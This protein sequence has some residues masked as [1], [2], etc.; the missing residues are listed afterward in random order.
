MPKY[1]VNLSPNPSFEINTSN[2]VLGGS[3]ATA[4]RSVQPS[5]SGSACLKVTLSS[6]PNTFTGVG[7]MIPD[8]DPTV[9]W[10]AY[11]VSVSSIGAARKFKTRVI[12]YNSGG[13]QIGTAP[14]SEAIDCAA[15]TWVRTPTHAIQTPAGAAT[16]R[17]YL[18]VFAPDGTSA[19]DAGAVWLTD[20][21]VVSQGFTESDARKDAT[22]FFDG[23][24][25]G[26][27]WTGAV[28]LS[29]SRRAGPSRVNRF[30]NPSSEAGTNG[31]VVSSGTL[32]RTTSFKGQMWNS[33][34]GRS[35]VYIT[36]LVANGTS[37][38]LTATA[39][40]SYQVPVVPGQ[41]VG[42]SV[43]I[44]SDPLGTNAGKGSR[45]EVQLI[46]SGGGAVG[47]E[48]GTSYQPAPL[49]DG[50]RY[51]FTFQVPAGVYAVRPRIQNFSGNA[52]TSLA[53]GQRAWF[54]SLVLTVGDTADEASAGVTTG[55]FDGDGQANVYMPGYEINTA[56]SGTPHD[57]ASY[58]WGVDIDEEALDDKL[59]WI[60]NFAPP[61]ITT[62]E[63]TRLSLG[64]VYLGHIEGVVGGSLEFAVP[65]SVKGAGTLNVIDYNQNIDWLTTRIKISCTVN[66]YEWDLGVFVPSVPKEAWS[67]TGRAWSIELL[68]KTCILDQDA[69]TGSF[70]L[71]EGT[72]VIN[73]VRSL[74]QST[75]ETA[76]SAITNTSQTLKNG[77]VWEPGTSKL[78]IIN[79]LLDTAG[80][81]A[82]WCDGSGMF[83][84]EPYTLP[85][86]RP[87][88]WE[89]SDI[90]GPKIYL[91]EFE[92]EQDIYAIPNRV[93][94]VSQTNSEEP[95]LVSTASNTDPNSP[96]SYQNRGRW[97]VHTETGVEVTSQ[98]ALNTYASKRLVDLSSV[99]ATFTIR[100]APVPL[101]LNN[102]TTFTRTPSDIINRKGAVQSMKI[103]L[104][105]TDLMETTFREVV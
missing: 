30:R 24:S 83:R 72:N 14:M 78:R 64:E 51:A 20:G 88:V 9:P 84:A 79:D 54:D 2:V 73:A 85:K 53:S 99:Q 25:P 47:V 97:I 89:F 50:L 81:F 90:T 17:V 104:D 28:G 5:S 37:A 40:P 49:Y 12:W 38:Y 26:A 95:S 13:S 27:S 32:T 101:Y 36:Q 75:G 31:W 76:T 7:Q 10:T 77:L 11:S 70:S 60:D 43:L 34:G 80:Y 21:W 67:A 45:A 93:V 55:Y 94:A 39:S 98:Q 66:G 44:A 15:D 18:Y 57:S 103:S 19:A 74:I 92:R 86:S 48:S 100:H 41:W 3:V 87:S 22:L 91:P 23:S 59:S 65:R 69:V 8:A 71:P 6:T 96:Y 16:C 1:Q 35:G 33:L 52:S 63:F 82:L 102:V 62:F 58:L 68:D 105:P 29:A 61:R 4:V 56:W 42:M 46:N